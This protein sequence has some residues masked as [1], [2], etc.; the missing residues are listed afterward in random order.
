MPLTAMATGL[1]T[2]TRKV[3]APTLTMLTVMVMELTTE[4]KPKI[5]RA[6]AKETLEVF[7]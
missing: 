5:Q 3:Q 1:Q 7:T 6:L 2:H 4:T